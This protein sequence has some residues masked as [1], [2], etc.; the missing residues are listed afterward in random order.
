LKPRRLK[1]G[2]KFTRAIAGADHFK[3]NFGRRTPAADKKF[4]PPGESL[5]A[6]SLV[7]D[8]FRALRHRRGAFFPKLFCDPFALHQIDNGKKIER[9]AGAFSKRRRRA[10]L[11]T[12]VANNP[13]F[14]GRF[15]T[16]LK[17]ARREISRRR[18][19]LLR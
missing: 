2:E 14:I 17:V 10:Q 9:R 6:D 11:N 5:F 15:A 7:F 4:A 3:S 13:Y 8:R 18:D 1:A 12:I 16:R 19:A